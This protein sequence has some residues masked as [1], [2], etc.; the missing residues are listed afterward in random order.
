M[1]AADVNVEVEYSYRR[2]EVFSAIC[3]ALRALGP[4]FWDSRSG[5]ELESADEISGHILIKAGR[6]MLS[7]G[8]S[9]SVSLTEPSAGRTRASFTSAPKV[10]FAGGEL[11]FGKNRR[12]IE[13]LIRETSTVL[14]SR[15]PPEPAGMAP[16]TPPKPSSTAPEGAVPCPLCGRS[17]WVS[18]L[19]HG[20]NYC[21][22]CYERFIVE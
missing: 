22:H 5:M 6:S 10:G 17:L 13:E 7:W 2:E 11:D 4:S 18:T 8:E 21:P 12:N 16:S 14:K 15:R 19:K 20:E 3:E 1:G 9:I